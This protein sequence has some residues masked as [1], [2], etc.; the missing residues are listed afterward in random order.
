ML[1]K[2]LVTPSA[3]MITERESG[4]TGISFSRAPPR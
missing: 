1:P 4:F 3:L 2:R